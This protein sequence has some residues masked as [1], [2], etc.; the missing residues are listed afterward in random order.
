MKKTLLTLA[1]VASL[2]I[3]FGVAQVNAGGNG[4]KGIVIGDAVELSTYSMKGISP[5]TKDE[6]QNRADQGFPVG[7]IEEETGDL[8]VCVYRNSAPASGVEPANEA[9]REFLGSK[10]VVQGLKY[11][12]NGVNVIRFSNISEY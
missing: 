4:E 7:V 11:K 9:M 8:W 1:L 5:E 2:A 6:M 10:V 12:A 3:S